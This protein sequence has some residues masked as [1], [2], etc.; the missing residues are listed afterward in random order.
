MITSI[1]LFLI[2]TICLLV[3]GYC[4]G[5]F[6]CVLIFDSVKFHK[7]EKWSRKLFYA[8]KDINKDNKITWFESTFTVDKTHRVKRMEI[9]FY[10][11]CSAFF[12]ASLWFANLPFVYTLIVILGFL[13]IYFG[14]SGFGFLL[15][16]KKYRP[17]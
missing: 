8:S 14:L 5:L 10:E 1:I 4:R 6:E 11:L 3:G 12:A 13:P 16:F 15:S 17:K 9:V 7:G 2:S